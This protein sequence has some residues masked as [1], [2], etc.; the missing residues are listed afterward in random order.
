M[1]NSFTAQSVI[2]N[3]TI[4]G[5]VMEALEE[6]ENSPEDI[7]SHIEAD[8]GVIDYIK[9]LNQKTMF[10]N[11]GDLLQGQLADV[12]NFISEAV[13]EYHFLDNNRQIA[14]EGM[15][16][17]PKDVTLEK[18]QKLYTIGLCKFLTFVK[19][20]FTKVHD[21]CKEELDTS[22]EA[23]MILDTLEQINDFEILNRVEEEQIKITFEEFM[24][25]LFDEEDDEDDD[26]GASEEDDMEEVTLDEDVYE[27]EE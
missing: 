13:R 21:K 12:A 22:D 4:A 17:A 6:V 15:M 24:D 14:E 16:A 8:L 3:C 18:V 10:Q 27:F 26:D 7:L 9:T 5:Q 1:S 23:T 25:I 11:I 19:L 2:E 20:L